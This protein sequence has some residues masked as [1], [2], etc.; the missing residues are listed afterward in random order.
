MSTGASTPE[1]T[2]T[3]TLADGDSAARDGRWVDAVT[4]WV[5]LREGSF[6]QEA[7]E[8]LRWLLDETTARESR[9]PASSISPW[10]IILAATGFGLLGTAI[11]LTGER[12]TGSLA[13]VASVSAWACYLASGVLILTY[14]FILHR[15]DRPGTHITEADIDVA[16][17]VARQLDHHPAPRHSHHA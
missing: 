7:D 15:R 11:V 16:S 14:A 10:S 13:V 8:R 1:P 6:R 2:S 4:I 17:Q 3:A 5:R 9:E 12:T